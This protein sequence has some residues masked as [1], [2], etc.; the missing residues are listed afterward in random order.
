LHLVSPDIDGNLS[1][2]VGDLTLFATDYIGAPDPRSDFSADGTV[3]IAD[4]AIFSQGFSAVC[5]P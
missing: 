4:L 2:D 1:V 3:G 5:Q